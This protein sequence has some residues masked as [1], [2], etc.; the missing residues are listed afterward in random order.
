M[1]PPGSSRPVPKRPPTKAALLLPG[2]KFHSKDGSAGGL[3]LVCDPQPPR[4]ARPKF[5]AALLSK[6]QQFAASA[7]RFF[8]DG[9]QVGVLTADI[10]E[11][12]VADQQMKK[13]P[14]HI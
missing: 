8:S 2:T 6:H 5:F 1:T 11:R 3:G 4:F 10:V 9:A 13:V 7:K 12:G 14:S